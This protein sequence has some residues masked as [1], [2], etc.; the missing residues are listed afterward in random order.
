MKYCFLL[1][2]LL[3]ITPTLPA[4]DS[5]P[6]LP[7]EPPEQL[8]LYRDSEQWIRERFRWF[9]QQREDADGSI[10]EGV[11]EAAWQESNRMSL[12]KPSV[13]LGK[14]GATASAR[15]TQLG[16]V[17]IGGRLT[18][19][20]IHPEN[21]DIVYFTAADGGVWKSVNATS[22]DA[23]FVPVSDD[24]PTLATGSIDIDPN[25]PDIIYLGTGEANG[26]ADSYPGVGVARS[27]DAG[28]TWEVIGGSQM[29]NIGA[30]RVHHTNGAI[31]NAASRQGL[32]RSLDSGRT[33]SSTGPGIAHDLVSHPTIDSIIYAGVQGQGILKSTDS[34]TT[35]T[36][37]DIGVSRDS[38]G[39]VAVDLCRTQPHILY[40]VL[41]ASRGPN[42][43]KT[44]AVVKSTDD[45]ATWERTLPAV[46]PTNFFSTYGWYNCEIG[47]HPTDPEKIQVGG[48]GHYLSLNGGKSFSMRSGVHVDQHALE[49]SA[50]DPDICFL[51]NDGGI[52]ISTNGGITFT[53][54]NS[55]LPIT[56]FY[57]LGIALQDPDL[58]MGGTQDRGS[59]TRHQR[60]EQWV[61][62]TGGDGGYCII[63]YSDSNY[64]YAEY[65]NGSHLRSTDG[66]A[67]WHSINNGLYGK[68][69]WVTP[70][71]IHPTDP[72]ILFT[73]TNR[74]LYKTTNRGSLWFPF[75]GNMDSART[76]NVIA[77]SPRVPST[78]LVGYTDGKIWKSTNSGTSWTR[79]S[80]GIPARL[81]TDII[82]DPSDDDTYYASFSGYIRESVFKTTN[83]GES[84]TSIAGNLP[85]IPTN[86]LEINPGNTRELY[87]GTDF[88][89]Y[90]TTNGGAEWQVLGE[91]MP[92]VVVVDLELHPLSGQLIAATHGRSVYGLTVT[93]SVD[94]LS[95]SATREG[96]G[97]HLQWRTTYE[98]STRGYAIERAMGIG[99]W[100]ELAYIDA[101]DAVAAVRMYAYHDATIPS[102]FSSLRYR[103]KQL[104][105][106]G[107]IEWSTVISVDLG[108]APESFALE[109][110]YPNPFNPGT[111]IRYTLPNSGAIRL[112]ITD[113]LG[114]VIRTMEDGIQYAGVHH[115]FLDASDLPSGAYF[116]HLEFAGRKETRKMLVMK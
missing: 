48:V 80:T 2:A 40:A 56:Q 46:N 55:N 92:K 102:G 32:F 37:L 94:L 16:P 14:T 96:S 7:V 71:V 66:G 68:G 3:I 93:T 27:T 58:M 99:D 18:G 19:I 112:Y 41:V 29:K 64:R 60:N 34:G 49:F 1:V 8:R 91:G 70:V 103:L 86:A 108:T 21:H 25:N 13:R 15:W 83:A 35:W 79:V 69:P 74:Q 90:I 113:A 110:N 30:I 4:Q 54:L 81:C 47:V 65:Q 101:G 26:S 28:M 31:I 57:E 84:W 85:S 105:H 100:E 115:V 22:P 61:R 107:G 59:N 38:I 42:V 77:I 11:R 82:F 36:E 88:G 104:R 106:D 95:F 5:A 51:G 44:L 63:D 97:V 45:G 9:K 89:V 98:G 33:W 67:R 53:G 72:T 62:S 50:I 111:T 78:M 73:C 43:N 6:F 10:P 87:V 75:H 20:A 23:S 116:Y 17:N 52:Y 12:Y 114:T 76:I 109:Q 24:L 39:R